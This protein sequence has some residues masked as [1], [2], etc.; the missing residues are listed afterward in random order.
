[1]A[2]STDLVRDSMKLLDEVAAR[3]DVI[4]KAIAKHCPAF[5]ASDKFGPVPAASC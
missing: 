4:A 1:V 3:V 5:P 2:N